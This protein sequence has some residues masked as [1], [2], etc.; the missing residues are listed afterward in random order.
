MVVAVKKGPATKTKSSSGKK[1]SSGGGKKKKISVKYHIECKN[2]V[3]DGI[4]NV[5]DFVSLSHYLYILC[6]CHINQLILVRQLE[7]LLGFPF[8][9]VGKLA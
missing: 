5:T 9:A 3:E 6:M 1:K 7:W 2:P 4:M 8:L